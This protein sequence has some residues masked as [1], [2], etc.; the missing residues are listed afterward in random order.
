M[1][2]KN[3][4]VAASLLVKVPDPAKPARGG[5]KSEVRSYTLR[6]ALAS[7]TFWLVFAWLVLITIG[8]MIVINSAAPI[9]A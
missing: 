4:I 9:A 7:P 6:E 5:T 2:I 8:A 3:I 1:N